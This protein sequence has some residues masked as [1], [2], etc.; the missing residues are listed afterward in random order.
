MF[1]RAVAKLRGIDE[2]GKPTTDWPSEGGDPQDTPTRR[3]E[4]QIVAPLA[5]HPPGEVISHE[6]RERNRPA[7]MT[8]WRDTSRRR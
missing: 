2:D 1:N 7:F 3:G 8:L 4:Y 5:G 6:S